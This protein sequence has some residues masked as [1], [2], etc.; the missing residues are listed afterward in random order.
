MS[1]FTTTSLLLPAY[2]GN[3]V[4]NVVGVDP[5]ATT[6]VLNC[7]FQ[8]D[9]ED[10]GLTKDTVILGPW[11]D[12]TPLPGAAI[13]GLYRERMTIEE[14][15]WTFSVQCDMSKTDAKTCTTINLGG[16]DNGSPT[17]TFPRTAIDTSFYKYHGYGRF[18][19]VPVTIAAGQDHIVAAKIASSDATPMDNA[20]DSTNGAEATA[21]EESTR[22]ISGD[23]VIITGE[24]GRTTSTAN[25][26]VV[27]ITGKASSPTSTAEDDIVTITGEA[28]PSETSGSEGYTFAV[29]GS[30]G[31][32]DRHHITLA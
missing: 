10:C 6:F 25:D 16:N 31:Q 14:E 26:D 20:P 17:A 24:A 30:E 28:E 5:T 21:S 18:T 12:K 4:A 22:T 8:K 29:N 27:I 9:K 3:F 15:D 23:V 7:D 1:S 19:W 11:A 13:T 2:T 32:A